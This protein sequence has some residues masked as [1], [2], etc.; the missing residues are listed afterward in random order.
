M[1]PERIA[2]SQGVTGDDAEK[3]AGQF[4]SLL[5]GDLQIKR[6]IGVLEQPSKADIDERSQS[7]LG[8]FLTLLNADQNRVTSRE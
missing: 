4:L 2:R 7:A 6:T 5:I 8:A 1:F 3:L